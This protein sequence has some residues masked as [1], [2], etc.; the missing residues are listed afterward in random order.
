MS[1][2][3]TIEVRQMMQADL[4]ETVSIHIAEFRESRSTSL[5]KPFLTK[6]Y[7]WFVVNQGLLSHVAIIENQQVGF[8]VGAV[9]GY[10]RKVF[11]YA[12]WQI[13]AGLLLHPSLLF[14]A[15][16]FKM[17]PSYLK[18]LTLSSKD[19]FP[20][21]A[22][23]QRKASLASI[24]VLENAQGMGV[25]IKLVRAF[26]SGAESLAVDVLG[27]SVEQD[28]HA[29]RSIYEKCGWDPQPVNR[30]SSTIYYMKTISK[31]YGRIVG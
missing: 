3:P 21:D 10:G 2:K 8:V 12:F 22:A 30:D 11:R 6:M 15:N 1:R 9:G 17:A 4:P 16:T 27:L 18:G 14:E 20:A 26:E 5:G 29:A 25:G 28:N 24:A 31:S 13:L 23:T 19:R 7:E